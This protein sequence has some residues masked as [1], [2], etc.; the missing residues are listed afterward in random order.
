MLFDTKGSPT[1]SEQ[2]ERS[3][4]A[5]RGEAVGE[6]MKEERENWDVKKKKNLINK[7]KC[8]MVNIQYHLNFFRITN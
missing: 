5:V 3:R 2:K 1:L 6:G 8:S 7:I 4:G